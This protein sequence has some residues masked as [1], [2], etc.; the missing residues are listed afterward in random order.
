MEIFTDPNT[1][2]KTVIVDDEAIDVPFETTA[3]E[4]LE[5]SGKDTNT[6]S[7]TTRDGKG[8]MMQVPNNQRVRLVDGQTFHS[9][10]NHS[11]G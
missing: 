1:R 7:L 4:I 11:G 2:T 8:N 5:R 6:R 3:M 9:T 10:L